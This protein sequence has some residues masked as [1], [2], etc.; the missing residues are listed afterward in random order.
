MDLQC[1]R[2]LP[3]VLI[4]LPNEDAWDEANEL[5]SSP[6]RGSYISTKQN[7]TTSKYSISSRPLPGV[8][9][10]LQKLRSKQKGGNGSRPLPGVLIS[11]RV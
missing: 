10:S 5:F 1:S 2:P 4:S 11:L 6:S 7:E 9:I 8:L 3:G